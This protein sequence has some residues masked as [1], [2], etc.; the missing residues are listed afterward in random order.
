MHWAPPELQA[1]EPAP[2]DG[3]YV[4]FVAGLVLATTLAVGFLPAMFAARGNLAAHVQQQSRGASGPRGGRRLRAGLV[5]AEVALAVLLTTGAMLLMRS[6]Q[7][8]LAVD[9]GFQAAQV[10]TFQ[11]NA[12]DRFTTAAERLEFYRTLFE[13]LETL[14]GVRHAG[15]TTR[16]PLGSPNVSTRIEAEGAPPRAGP[17]PEVEFRR[18]MHDY[19][20]AMGIPIL[21]GRGFTAAD[22]SGPP[23][24]VVNETL[25]V[26][27]F[28]ESDP[29][30][31]RVRMQPAAGPWMAI[32]GVVR[33]VHHE[34]LDAPPRPELYV[35]YASNPPVA[36]FI[37]LRTAVPPAHLAE[38]VRRE[39]RALDPSAAPYD[40]RSMDEIQANS[41]ADRRFTITLLGGFALAALLLAAAGVYGVA[42]LV[43]AERTAEIGLRMALGARPRSVVGL[44]VRQ[45]CALALLGALAGAGAGAIAAPL[46]GSQL[47]GV[48]SHD[49]L[50]FAVVPL[51][52]VAVAGLASLGPA[53]RAA[54]LDPL[55]ALRRD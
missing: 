44:I 25:A 18:A 43:T 40:L 10:L 39:I 4:V 28:G 42:A 50:T 2:A 20:A 15:G 36:P 19:F 14:P 11:L 23:V 49:P 37:V 51:L 16:I 55:L 32:V 26:Q 24:A 53:V 35:D 3:L 9:P 45:S 48:H 38:P 31:R 34:G 54:R 47:F 41:I 1:I 46:I 7:A 22:A 21:R 29:L 52:L 13:R 27:L 8:L 30:G 17:W 5:V 12:P 33:N 6:F